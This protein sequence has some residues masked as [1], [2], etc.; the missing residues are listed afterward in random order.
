VSKWLPDD[1]QDTAV[2]RCGEAAGGGA[3]DGAG[4]GR[5]GWLAAAGAVAGQARAA[6]NRDRLAQLLPPM[7]TVRLGA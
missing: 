1:Y 2:P 6:A 5:P 4:A 7:R 3:A